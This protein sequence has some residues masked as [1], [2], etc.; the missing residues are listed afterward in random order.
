VRRLVIRP[1]GIGDTILS[2]PALEHLKTDYT[3]IWVRSEIVPLIRFAD[4]VR[5][6]GSTGIELAGIPGVDP[7]PALAPELSGFDEIVTWYGSNRPEFR[8][9]LGSFCSRIR[10]L[11][12]LPPAGKGIHAADFFLQQ[13]GGEGTAIPRI[14]TDARGLGDYIVLHPFSGSEKKN[15]PYE[16]FVELE[17]ELTGEGCRVEWAARP[18]QVRFG[19]LGQ[20]AGWLACARMFVGNDSGITH[21]ASAVGTPVIALFGPTDPA[22][23]GPRGGCVRVM[24]ARSLDEIS[25]PGV[26]AAVLAGMAGATAGG[27]QPRPGW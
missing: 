26:K 10:F 5:P 19:D 12:A 8:D 27:G 2:F 15:W 4:R 1:G 16:R 6:I 11:T 13:V 22:E 9:Y 18:G 20:L 7:P 23:W 21:L 24:R 17:S 14:A 3:E 25:L